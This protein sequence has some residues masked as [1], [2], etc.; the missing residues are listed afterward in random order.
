MIFWLR[1]TRIRSVE[2]S[3]R[4]AS[5]LSGTVREQIGHDPSQR[6]D[7][8]SVAGGFFAFFFLGR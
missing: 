3:T 7:G 1:R 8:L 5:A 4:S 2:F 6:M